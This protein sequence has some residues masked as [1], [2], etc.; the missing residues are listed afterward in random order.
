MSLS[1][2]LT[3]PLAQLNHE[4]WESLCDGCGLCCLHKLEFDEEPGLIYTTCVSC[5][6]LDSQSGRCRD[7]AGRFQTVPNC[8][9]LSLDN[10][11]EIDWLPETCAYRCRFEERAIPDWHPL[12]T[13][14]D[15]PKTIGVQSMTIVNENEVE[16]EEDLEDYIVEL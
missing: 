3:K 16:D 12:V 9:Q 7:Y 4:E 14:R 1:N 13:G 2:A 10:L 5:Q 8:T 15:I 6:L 11:A